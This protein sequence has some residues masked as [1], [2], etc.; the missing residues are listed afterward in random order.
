M[1]M[2]KLF[3]V[4]IALLGLAGCSQEEPPSKAE[5]PRTELAY[6]ST[7][8]IRNINPHLY[9]GEM[10]AQN[11]VFE[12]LVVNT[13]EGVKPWLAESWEISPDGKEYT[14]HLRKD[15]AFTD[16]T[17]FN[18]EAV[19][20]NMDAIVSNLP[21]HAWLDMVNEIDRNEAVDEYTYKLV[22]K[23]PYYPTLVELGLT[24]PFRFISPKCFIDGETK[25]GVSGYVGTGPW[26]LTEHKDKQYAVFTRNER[27][28]G[29]KPALESVRW[30]VMPDHQTILLALQKGEIDLI[31]GSDGDMLNLDA[32]AA[33]QKEGAT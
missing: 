2:G 32:F 33:L 4:V 7:K 8:D 29:P 13:K 21:R 15:V 22:L 28:W 5:A 18:A 10:A 11:M 31:F 24:R 16:G 27:Y 23:H 1:F 9:S 12:P 30:K 20:A 25:N 26:V 17:P 3:V 19:K 6:A 14:F